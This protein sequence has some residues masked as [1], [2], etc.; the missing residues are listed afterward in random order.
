MYFSGVPQPSPAS[1]ARRDQPIRLRLRSGAVRRPDAS[2]SMW[3][4][5]N[6]IAIRYLLCELQDF[7]VLFTVSSMLIYDALCPG[8]VSLVMAGLCSYEV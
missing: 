5:L 2:N 4:H 6:C 8:W 1:A 3:Q 7:I